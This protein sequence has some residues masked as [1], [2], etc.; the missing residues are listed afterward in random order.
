M[1]YFNYKWLEKTNYEEIRQKDSNNVNGGFGGNEWIDKDFAFA[2]KGPHIGM[3][4]M[5][6]YVG[7]RF[8]VYMD[9]SNACFFDGILL[10]SY[11]E[12]QGVCDVTERKHDFRSNTTGDTL[13]VYGDDFTCY[14][15]KD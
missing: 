10:R 8:I 15:Y 3:Y 5:P 7:Q 13:S 9:E 1:V 12:D 2:H 11:E 6:N 14:L 4:D